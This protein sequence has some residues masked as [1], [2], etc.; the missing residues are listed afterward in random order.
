MLSVAGATDVGKRRE[1]N[2]DA[3]LLRPELGLYVVADGAGGHN[4]GKV[5]SALAVTSLRNF[6]G[7]TN[8]SARRKPSLDAFGIRNGARRLAAAIQKANR[9]IVEISKSSG[10]L[11]AGWARRWSRSRSIFT[12][13]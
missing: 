11:T 13:R 4:A 12:S 10:E 8:V 6:F 2:E 3:I 5:A 9:D 1:Q 7:A